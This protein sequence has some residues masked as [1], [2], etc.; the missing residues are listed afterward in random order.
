M[1]IN[2]SFIIPHKNT[3]NLLQKCLDSIPRREDVQVIVVDDNSDDNKVDFKHFPGVDDPNVEVYFTKE[4]RGA[5][6]AK[7]VGLRHAIGKWIT[8][9]GADDYYDSC[10]SEA[11][12][13]YVNSDYDVI[14]FKGKSFFLDG[15]IS[16]RGDGHNALVD[17]AIETGDNVP[18]LL[19]SADA[20]KFYRREMLAS[21]GIYFNEVRWGNDVV[22]SAKVAVA[23]KKC[24]VSD[25]PIYCVTESAGN[26][27]KAT[28]LESQICRLRQEIEEVRITKVRYSNYSFIYYWLFRCWFSVYKKDKYQALKMLP[29]TIAAGGFPFLKEML[30]AKFS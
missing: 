4:G 27:T 10:L 15:S 1:A 23:C 14:I 6:Y 24:L 2:F 21:K 28:S 5:G 18:C 13:L 16:N 30:N 3:P 26:L 8:L 29:S 25:L 20:R 17:K 7:N 22:F 9:C 11:M 12:D 19:E